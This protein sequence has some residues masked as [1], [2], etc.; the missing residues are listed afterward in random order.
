MMMVRRVL[1]ACALGA[2]LAGCG[3]GSATHLVPGG[4]G[5]SPQGSDAAL[6]SVGNAGIHPGVTAL[7][8]SAL[9]DHATRE[10]TVTFGDASRKVAVSSDT[11]VATISPPD[12][13]AQYAGPNRFVASYRI[14]PVG[15]GSATITIT[16]DKGAHTATIAVSVTAPGEHLYVGG[17]DRVWVYD[18]RANG[19]A[20]PLRRVTGVVPINLAPLNDISVAADGTLAVE[21]YDI[22][23]VAGGTNILFYAP[24]ASDAATPVRTVTGIPQLSRGLTRQSDGMAEL[25]Y[26]GE[27]DTFAAG[28]NGPGVTPIRRLSMRNAVYATTDAQGYIYASVQNPDATGEV[29]VYAPNASGNAAPIRKIQ[30]AQM[31]VFQQQVS[32]LAVAPDGT[33]YVIGSTGGDY[34]NGEIRGIYAFPPGASGY[35]APSRVIPI[36]KNAGAIAVDTA[37]EIF[38]N[39]GTQVEVFSPD[40]DWGSAPIRTITAPDEG[41]NRGWV[42]GLAI[43]P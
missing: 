26:L 30:F 23:S 11:S 38:V 9:G 25:N 21:D 16:D 5:V 7:T 31:S 28:A 19:A 18:I 17:G 42:Y 2:A 12:Q 3:G 35:T 27:L 15:P 13:R 1:L 6:R 20:A 43:G 40:L 36:G 33:V 34:V 8:F 14:T 29:D 4:T 10:I 32:H 22:Y 24:G 41:N 37:G 39:Y